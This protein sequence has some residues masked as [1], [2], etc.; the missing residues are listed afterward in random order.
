MGNQGSLPMPCYRLFFR[1]PASGRFV[2]SKVLDDCADDA[3][4]LIR[5]AGEL[6]GHD[7]ELWERARLLAVLR[8]P[9]LTA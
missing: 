2:A 5:L 1:E 7:V 4:A 9:A 6:N 8:A 3:E